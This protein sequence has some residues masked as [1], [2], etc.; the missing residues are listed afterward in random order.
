MDILLFV[1]KK[2]RAQ[3]SKPLLASKPSASICLKQCFIMYYYYYVFPVLVLKGINL[4]LL[5]F[6]R[7]LKQIEVR[8]SELSSKSTKCKDESEPFV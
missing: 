5:L 4:S 1:L 6:A 7:G 3:A 8:E 2:V